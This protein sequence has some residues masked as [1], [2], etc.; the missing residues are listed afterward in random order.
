MT[1]TQQALALALEALQSIVEQHDGYCEHHIGATTLSFALA[2]TASDALA[3]KFADKTITAREVARQVFALCEWFEDLPDGEQDSQEEARF[4]AGQRFSA[5]R[6]RN[7]I[8][9]WLT[10]EENARKQLAGAAPAAVAEPAGD[11]PA[12]IRIHADGSYSD[13]LLLGRRVEIVRRNSGAWVPLYPREKAATPPPTEPSAE[14]MRCAGCDIPNGCPEYCRCAPASP[15]P[16]AEVVLPAGEVD[17]YLLA[18]SMHCRL[19]RLKKFTPIDASSIWDEAFEEC[20]ATVH[21]L[22]AAILADRAARGFLLELT[23]EQVSALAVHLAHRQRP[24]W[25]WMDAPLA[26]IEQA[27]DKEHAK[28]HK[29][30]FAAMDA[31]FHGITPTAPTQARAPKAGEKR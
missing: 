2:N 5:K 15:E 25:G 21:R 9:T 7:G 30:D 17:V 10:D 14:P 19:E 28:I 8:G 24:A 31:Q 22:C 27:I 26:A 23:R 12:W 6:I 16:S 13:E 11:A 18:E 29:E 4:K 20:T 3:P 1:P